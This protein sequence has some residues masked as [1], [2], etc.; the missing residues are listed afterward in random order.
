MS[1]REELDLVEAAARLRVAYHTAHRLVLTG[2]L[3]GWRLDG[4]W[5]VDA[6]DLERL[7]KERAEI[8][9]SANS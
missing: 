3:K 6:C 5:F 7:L 8:S 1:E 9:S 4:R 2:K